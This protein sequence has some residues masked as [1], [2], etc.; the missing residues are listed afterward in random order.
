MKV[1]DATSACMYICISKVLKKKKEDTVCF[2]R[3]REKQAL[4]RKY[5]RDTKMTNRRWYF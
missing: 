2:D 1:G 4:N 3:A 5:V